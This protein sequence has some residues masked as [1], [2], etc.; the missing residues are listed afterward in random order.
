MNLQL[1][2]PVDVSRALLYL[3]PTL[4]SFSLNGFEVSTSEIDVDNIP[5]FL[6]LINLFLQDEG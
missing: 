4:H 6:Q 3:G 1:P 5:A 2:V